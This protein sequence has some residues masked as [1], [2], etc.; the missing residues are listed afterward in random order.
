MADI[1]SYIN[2]IKNAEHGR[3][4][5]DSIVNALEAENSEST[6][7]YNNAAKA[8]D[9]IKTLQESID[10]TK[11]KL[12]SKVNQ[13]NASVDQL[14]KDFKNAVDQQILQSEYDLNAKLSEAEKSLTGKHTADVS[15]LNARISNLDSTLSQKHKTDIDSLTAQL[16]EAIVKTNRDLKNAIDANYLQ[17][18]V[19]ASQAADSAAGALQAVNDYELQM[20]VMNE[21]IKSK[22]DDAYANDEGYLYLT[23]DQGNTVVGPIGP[24]AGGSGGGS[25]GSGA[26][27]SA[28]LTLK[29]R[30]E[31]S[32]KTVAPGQECLISFEWSSLEEDIPTGN[33]V[34]TVSIGGIP[35]IVRNIEQGF[36]SLDLADHLNPGT[37]SI[38][39]TVSDVYENRKYIAFTIKVVAISLTSTFDGSQTFSGPITYTYVPMGAVEKTVHFILD[40][41]EHGTRIVNTTGSQ[42]SYVIPAQTHGSH[43]LEVY[44]TCYIEG[45]PVKSNHLYYDLICVDEDSLDPVIAVEFNQ[46]EVKQYDT[47]NIKYSVYNPLSL[48]S[49]VNLKEGGRILNTLTVDRNPQIWAYRVDEAGPH[50]L[51]IESEGIEKSI[52]FTVIETEVNVKPTE[53]DLKLYLSSYGRSNG[54][55]N[56]AS[57]GYGDIQAEFNNFNWISDGW[58]LDDDGITVLRVSGDA[59]LTIPYQIFKDDFRATGKTIEVELATRDVRDY[60]AEILTCYSGDRGLI[61]TGQ[62]ALLTSEQSEIGIQYKENEPVRLSFVINKRADYRLI[63]VYVDGVMSGAIQYPDDD[64]FSQTEPVG[65]SIGSND[66]TVDLYTIRV[67]DNNLTDQQILD[68]WIADT[69]NGAL[70][71]ERFNHND[72]FDDYGRVAIEKLPADLPYIKWVSETLPE[73]KGNKLTVSGSYTDPIDNDK[74]FSFENSQIDVQGTSSAGYARKNFKQKF[75]EGFIT[76]KGKTDKYALRTGAIP[77]DT[78]TFKADVASSEGANNVELVRLYNDTIPITHPKG[79]GYRWGIDGLPIVAFQQKASGSDFIGKYNFN[80]D[81]STEDLYG[82]EPGD[83]SWETLNNTALLALFDSIDFSDWETTFEARYPE[84]NTDISNLKK[85]ITWVNSTKGNVTKFKNELSQYFDVDAA[86]FYWLFTETFLMVDSRAKNAFPTYYANTGKWYFLPYDFD[87]ALGINNEGL[88]AFGYSLEDTDTLEGDV[89]VFNGQKSVFWNNVRDAFP[90]EIKAMYQKLRSDGAWSY[91]KIEKMFTDHQSKWPEAIINRDGEYKYLDPLKEE[92]NASYLGML[93]GTKSSQRKWWLYNRMRY[94]DSKYNAGDDLTDAITL[95]G[96]AKADISVTPYADLYVNVKYGSAMVSQRGVKNETYTLACPLSNVNDTEIYIYSS[97]QIAS[98]GD[99]SPLKVG[100]ADFSKATKLSEL[101]LGDGA[102]T[103][104]NTNLQSLSLGNNKLL[105]SLDLRNCTNFAQTID[106]TGCSNIEEIYL[107]GTKVT[108]INLPNGGIIKT[109]HFPSTLSN[110]TILNH[111]IQDL[112]VPDYSRLTTLRLENTGID[113]MEIIDEIQ[114]QTRVR[115]IGLNLEMENADEISDL[116]DKFDLF[117]GLDEQG[118]N[119]DQAQVSGTIH[120]PSVLGSEVAALQARYPYMTIKADHI[121]CKVNYYKPVGADD[122]LKW[123]LGYT[124]TVID[125]ADATYSGKFSRTQSARYTYEQDGWSR[126]PDGTL[127]ANAQKAITKDTDLYAHYKATEKTFTINYYCGSDLKYTKSGVKYGESVPYPYSTAELVDP[128]GE[129]NPFEEWFP[130]GNNIT[131]D[132]NCYAQFASPIRVEDT[133]SDDWDELVFH[134]DNGEAQSLYNIKDIKNMKISS[135]GN[136]PMQLAGFDIDNLADKSGKAKTTWIGYLLLPDRKR[137]NPILS[138]TSGNYK[139][140]TGTIG[141]FSKSSLYQYLNETIFSLLPENI[142]NAIKEVEIEGN[143]Y[144]TTGS[145][146]TGT[147]K[148]KIFTPEYTDMKGSSAKYYDLFKDTYSNIKRNDFKNSSPQPYWT[149]EVYDIRNVIQAT[150]NGGNGASVVDT[151][152]CVL[153]CFCI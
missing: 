21:E 59:R 50:T 105:K 120:V 141:G 89:D 65:I 103:Y 84:E 39:V 138:G 108:G 145:K 45:M 52:S 97:S 8:V 15:V 104:T 147:Y 63:L 81:K 87:T 140:G 73:Y 149:S 57:W 148:A 113:I 94:M 123:E 153:I 62:Q 71:I 151:E 118:Q 77:V 48:T 146:Q 26:T 83:E 112:Q 55:S 30:S 128:S 36:I 125:G 117:R 116:F 9:S 110:L 6:L 64:D 23:G 60:D 126:T 40:G 129:N 114:P 4:V 95:R 70:K 14:I 86:L 44:F 124:E 74:S 136:L 150:N 13:S 35:V 37:N 106:V 33:G 109:L 102:G 152:L 42:Q 51:T 5:R 49:T 72:V 88:L 101:K 91:E 130:N 27:N 115:L 47:L 75:K 92:G 80:N 38:R 58:Q 122:T 121:S 68:N 133:I 135:I 100:F 90:D 85:M 66:C 22:I 12:E 61:L 82:L 28:I 93:Q 20:A 31:F 143:F 54:E 137:W 34:V 11:T 131:D 7:A 107:E 25:G 132:R 76:N 96:Y 43:T 53:E 32:T 98:V 41:K 79:E 111:K 69:Q 1:K 127:D 134:I 67:Y 142:R 29:N 56:P 16:N 99:L 139:E 10:D 119:M 46:T 19:L 144:D 78:F 17:M 2:Q 3:E 24:F 18:S